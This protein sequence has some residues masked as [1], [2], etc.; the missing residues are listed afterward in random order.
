M[1]GTAVS[2]WQ[3]IRATRAEAS[4][5]AARIEAEANFSKALAAVD[6]MLT[7]VG[8]ETLANIP[9]MEPV[10]RTLLEKALTFYQD[11]LQQRSTE[12]R[13]RLESARAYQRVSDIY[14]MLGQHLQAEQ[15]CRQ[16]IAIFAELEA[17]FPDVSTYREE[18][19]ESYRRL[20]PLIESMAGQIEEFAKESEHALRQA[21]TRLEKLAAEFPDEPRYGYA[22]ANTYGELAHILWVDG[23]CEEA[24]TVCR[25]AIEL[26]GRLSNRF[27]AMPDEHAALANHY[28]RLGEVLQ[29]VGRHDEAER[30]FRG[31][32]ELERKT[33]E[34]APAVTKYQWSLALGLHRFG[35]S[36]YSNGQP[37]E[38]EQ[39][40]QEALTLQ[41][42]IVQDFPNVWDYRWELTFTLADFGEMLGRGGRSDEAQTQ[43][44][45][46]VEI[47]RPTLEYRERAVREFPAE[48]GPHRWG[49][50]SYGFLANLLRVAGRAEDAIAVRR[51]KTSFKESNAAKFTED[52]F[53]PFKLA[54]DHAFLADLLKVTSRHEEAA[55]EYLR[56]AELLK[57]PVT[58]PPEHPDEVHQLSDLAP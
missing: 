37:Q 13:I 32:V 15:A 42:A 30:Y 52:Q 29:Q 49:Y 17:Q 19:A 5:T 22:L 44:A 47:Y 8:H 27:P 45:R 43:F 46:A 20:G 11:F 14:Y 25:K 48:T 23:R 56:A 2:A 38:A 40:F 31:A 16:A 53:N 33:A 57:Q 58:K 6:E 39:A 4:A 55:K 10:R 54:F 34:H 7:Q 26:H 50:G 35:K 3:A 21:L 12:P 41:E 36:L 9:Q 24:E 18:A 51:K 1:L 28:S